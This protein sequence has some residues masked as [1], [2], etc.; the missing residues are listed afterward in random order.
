MNV[1]RTARASGGVCI[2]R[3]GRPNSVQG[4]SQVINSDLGIDR[5]ALVG[6]SGIFRRRFDTGPTYSLS[7]GQKRGDVTSQ[8]TVENV[9]YG[10]SVTGT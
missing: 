4:S 5:A 3:T 6:L 8:I 2:M 10:A 9:C 1:G 7:L